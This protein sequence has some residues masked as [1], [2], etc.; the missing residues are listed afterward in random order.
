MNNCRQFDEIGKGLL[1]ARG[2]ADDRTISRQV[3]KVFVRMISGGSVSLMDRSSG[4]SEFQCSCMRACRPDYRDNGW[5]RPPDV[6]DDARSRPPS[7]NSDVVLT[8]YS[9]E[10]SE[11]H[12]AVESPLTLHPSRDDIAT[13][14]LCEGSL[15]SHIVVGRLGDL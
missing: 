12:W 10:V 6:R 15:D 8:S 7:V 2:T 13:H 11:A 4:P 3:L 14:R 9:I 1:C 5:E